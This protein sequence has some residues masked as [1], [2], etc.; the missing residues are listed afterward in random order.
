MENL[1]KRRSDTHF[2]TNPIKQ[3][4]KTMTKSTKEEYGVP[5]NKRMARKKKTKT[6]SQVFWKFDAII[7]HREKCGQLQVLIQWTNTD[8]KTWDPS[9]E[10]L[11]AISEDEE[12]ACREY[13]EEHDLLEKWSEYV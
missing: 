2:R 4:N 3:E 6:K 12:K 10:P 7:G 1:I 13:A 11:G 9:W 8:H 5:G